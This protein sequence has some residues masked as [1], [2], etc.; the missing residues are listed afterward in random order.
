VRGI[1]F[2]FRLAFDSS[3]PSLSL[4]FLFLKD[5]TGKRELPLTRSLSLLCLRPLPVFSWSFSPMAFCSWSSR[6]LV[7][8]LPR[9]AQSHSGFQPPPLRL[10]SPF[11]VKES[12][13]GPTFFCL[14]S[15]LLKPRVNGSSPK[16][17]WTQWLLSFDFHAPRVFCFR[18][19]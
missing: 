11:P 13:P 7:G 12:P 8:I 4:F 14:A 15:Q 17:S 3:P 10:F 2:Q 1:P 5:V 6:S 18:P 16:A 19:G 9:P